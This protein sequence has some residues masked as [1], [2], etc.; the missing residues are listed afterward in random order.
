M[1]FL[2]GPTNK[3]TWRQTHK[4]P[5]QRLP[6]LMSPQALLERWTAWQSVGEEFMRT[7]LVYKSLDAALTASLRPQQPRSDYLKVLFGKRS[8]N[9]ERVAAGTNLIDTFIPGFAQRVSS[10]LIDTSRF[11]FAEAEVQLMSYG[12]GSTVFLIKRPEKDWVLKIYRRS[13]GKKGSSLTRIANHFKEKYETVRSWYNG[14]FNLVPQAHFLILYGP[15]FSNPAAAVLQPF[16]H[17]KKSD[18]FLDY[19]NDKLLELMGND[20][21][22]A[23]NFLFFAE[24][25]LQ[26]YK[27]HKLCVDF[28]GRENLMLVAQNNQ[29]KLLVVDNGIFDLKRLKLNT[30]SLLSRIEI[31]LE[32]LDNLKTLLK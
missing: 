32:R 18:F 17:G 6:M 25:T 5:N 16:I 19:S 1:T 21:E 29:H 3:T 27:R 2:N 22:L 15:I 20:Q 24:Q 7:R 12:S 23:E 26:I 8:S 14:P 11:P 13:L 10:K 4:G 28:L 31:R 9:Y 30:P